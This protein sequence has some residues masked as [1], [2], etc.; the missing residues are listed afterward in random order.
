MEI[1]G[2]GPTELIFIIIIAILVMGPDQ[3]QNA[4][5]IVAKWMRTV[6]MSDAWMAIRQVSRETR[7]QWTSFLREANDDLQKIDP[8]RI[9]TEPWQN[10]PKF[11]QFKTPS[12]SISTDAKREGKSSDPDPL[13]SRRMDGAPQTQV[14]SGSMSIPDG[15]T[16]PGATSRTD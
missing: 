9:G 5:R 2:I 16:N 7:K 10:K 1:L 13:P 14:D 4:G 8:T 11:S 3:M 15:D 6:L 12:K